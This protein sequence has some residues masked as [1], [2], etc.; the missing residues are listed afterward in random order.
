[1]STLYTTLD[2]VLAEFTD[3]CTCNALRKILG[4]SHFEIYLDLFAY[5]EGPRLRDR[6]SHG[7]ADLAS[8]RKPLLIHLFN[9][10]A[11]TCAIS[12]C[13][14]H[15]LQKCDTL[16]SLRS[17]AVSYQSHFHPIQLLRKKVLNTIE[18]LKSWEDFI[19]Q[20]KLGDS[21]VHCDPLGEP[22]EHCI[23]L[24]MSKF[25]I[26]LPVQLRTEATPGT[27]VAE[28]SPQTM[29]RPRRELEV[30]TML[31]QVCQEAHRSLRQVHGMLVERTERWRLHQLRSRQRDNYKRLL[32]SLPVLREGAT[33]A[34]WIVCCCLR[35]I[36]N[37]T[38]LDALQYEKL[39][40]LLKT[41]LKFS[42]NFGTLT[43]SSKNRWDECCQL[44]YDHV[45]NALRTL[46]NDQMSLFSGLVT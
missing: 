43:S 11:A 17:V 2:E 3:N 41:T 42:E 38:T 6:I 20:E 37:M 18:A 21:S 12:L 5:L 16:G 28:H 9:A 45:D 10:V 30:T 22:A 31:R 29:F 24:L 36:N 14:N 46:S 4:D 44:C 13:E 27:L 8:I 33:L 32:E 1:M 39:V 40:R 34:L 19:V 7:E 15:K 35:R 25:D 23:L 26:R